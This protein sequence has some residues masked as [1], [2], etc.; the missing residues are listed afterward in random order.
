MP[1]RYTSN[2]ASKMTPGLMVRTDSM[3]IGWCHSMKRR[4][5]GYFELHAESSLTTRSLM[6]GFATG[7]HLSGWAERPRS[8]LPRMG[9]CSSQSIGQNVLL[10]IRRTSCDPLRAQRRGNTMLPAWRGF[11]LSDLKP[12]AAPSNLNIEQQT[13]L[14]LDWPL[15]S[16]S[17]WNSRA[18]FHSRHGPAMSKARFFTKLAHQADITCIQE[19]HVAC[20]EDVDLLG[21][22]MH[23]CF[24]SGN[25][26][27]TG[28][29]LVAVKH[30]YLEGAINS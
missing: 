20:A 22:T 24:W 28:G 23:T 17:S 2:V 7:L 21:L 12:D 8:M 25:N 6:Y 18:L 15:P 19:A 16:I 9:P 10:M 4:K 14:S 5:V 13:L 30:A 1:K 11:V 3:Q 29:L 26:P 27:A